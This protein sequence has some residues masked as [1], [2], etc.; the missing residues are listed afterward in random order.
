VSERRDRFDSELAELL[1]D[2]PE[3][4]RLA[5]QVRESR[6][7]PDLDPRF[8]AILRARLMTEAER[9]LVPRRGYRLAPRGAMAWGALALGVALVA[10]TVA[11]IV[12]HLPASEVTVVA[13]NV[14]HRRSVDPHQPI[15]LSF[16]QPMDE[17][18]VATAL[19]IEPATQVT[20]TWENPETLV[21]TPTHALAS[22]TDYQ[23]TIPP[24][25]VHSQS[26]QT[27]NSSVVI[28]FGTAPSTPSPTASPAPAL[29]PEAIGPAAGDAQAFWGP[30]GAPGATVST[31]VEAAPGESPSPSPSAPAS[32]AS[33]AS[34]TPASTLTE[35]AYVFPAGQ[36]AVALSGAPASAVA[37]SPNLL[38]V[39][40]AVME[41]D[42]DAAVVV[43]NA[44]GSH[45]SQL[46][47]T[48][49]TAGA[50]V[51]ALAW[52]GDN[53]IVFVTPQG[54]DAV[55]LDLQWTQLYAFA[56]GGSASGVVLAP[57]GDYAF[58]P[59]ADV[60]SAAATS[61]ASPSG[62]GAVASPSAPAS[63][64]AAS[65]T[66]SP[67]AT[68]LP[69]AGD[70]WLLTLPTGGGSVPTPVQLPG[71]SS[72]VVTF[73]GSGDEVAW[74]EASGGVSTVLAAPT[75]EPA[76]ISAVSG[77]PGEGVDEMALDAHGSTIAYGLGEGGIEVTTA[78]GAVLGVSTDQSSSLAFSPDG[79]EL[80]FVAAG[81]LDVAQVQP[82][83]PA[84]PTS[85]C[86]AADPVLSR[87]VDAQVAH[88]VSA[89]AALSA[90]GVSAGTVTPATVDRGYVVSSSCAAST[91][92]GGPAL[93]ASAR[94]VVDPTGSS[95]GQLTDETLVVGRSD[96][97]WLVTA[98]S[99]PPLASQGGGPRVLS[100]GVTPPAAAAINPET[101][102]TVTFDSDLEA[103]S[104]TAATLSLETASGQPISL[105]GAPV[106]DPDTR[107]ATLTVAG[108]LAA[109]TEVV[110]GTAMTDIDGRHPTATALYPVGG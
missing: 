13:S 1:G 60:P 6:P 77:A 100:V 5:Q 97:Q 29:Q 34:A 80:A 79:S 51:M 74:V 103:S 95:L 59:A 88:D 18:S 67:T 98:L 14:S 31:G 93:T 96:G 15:T 91:A 3:L 28:D 63:A 38:Y 105:L 73:S 78:G 41:P 83:S 62:G 49:S 107:E 70:G 33:S 84:S 32:P 42:G 16:N 104:V 86:A 68:Y 17:R 53:Q 4:L 99:V 56:G 89:L 11:A 94:L 35:G 92:G 21:V 58:I 30:D 85:V 48:G 44:D 10:G 90:P 2:D 7:E 72:G 26:G 23:V 57:D 37:V 20:E 12:S 108:T 69:T 24:G 109:G 19:R 81:S 40:L 39:A 71:S 43:E 22:D 75:D 82:A 36:T 76:A 54:I 87:F 8:P 66:A 27:L 9:V 65:A 110:V 61:T 106:Y 45:P 55:D 46:W 50:P 52:D 101:V 25:S 102:V 64:T 47:P